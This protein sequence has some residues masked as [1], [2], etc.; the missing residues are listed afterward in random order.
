L[1]VFESIAIYSGLIAAI[2]IFI[3]VYVASRFYAGY[4]HSKQ[5]CSEL[6]ATGSPTEKLSPLINNYPLGF[7]FCFFGWYLAQL[8]NVSTLVNI[9]G[10]LVIVHGIGTWVAGYF[11]MDAD[12][13]TKSPTLNCKIH[14]WAGFIMLLSLVIAPILIAISP[15]T[16]I[17]PL[18]FRIFSV[19][20]VIAAVYYLFA[21]AKAVKSQSNPGIHQ[22]ISYGFQLIW[23]SIFSLVLV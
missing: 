21:M 19:V 1:V 4:S 6:G 15:T 8:T 20:S 7:L 22:R 17:I 23:L 16:E 11:P 18:Y 14:S 13:F 2:W 5:F 10:W 12:P 3:G 9:A